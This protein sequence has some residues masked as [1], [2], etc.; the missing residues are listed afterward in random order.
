MSTV[1]L[2]HAFTAH[3]ID[4]DV[5]AMREDVC[6]VDFDTV[7]VQQDL[8]DAAFVCVDGFPK[9]RT[10]RFIVDECR[11]R[12]L[13]SLFLA[14]QRHSNY[15]RTTCEL[16]LYLIERGVPVD[17]RERDYGTALSTCVISDVVDVAE[18]LVVDHKADANI[19]EVDTF[20][21]VWL[22]RCRSIEMYRM[23]LTKSNIDVRARKSGVGW[24]NPV[25]RALVCRERGFEKLEALLQHPDVDV[26]TPEYSDQTPLREAMCMDDTRFVK[27]LI[28]HGADWRAVS[29]RRM[30]VSVPR[31][32]LVT[33]GD[34]YE[35]VYKLHYLVTLCVADARHRSETRMTLRNTPPISRSF[36]RHRLFDRN[37]IGKVFEYL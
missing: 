5:D 36:F 28:A 4:E 15:C 16:L 2:P 10:I 34:G 24:Y 20:W 37:V 33:S 11:F 29:T 1:R 14:I 21:K 22:E 3:A 6:D 31:R 9:D 13:R 27:A 26:N 12:F 17:T 18:K 35:Y 30:F 32:R 8:F 25:S 23:L 7:H 19:G